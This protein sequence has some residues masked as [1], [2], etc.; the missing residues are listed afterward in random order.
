[1]E[2]VLL[3][4][5]DKAVFFLNTIF[6]PILIGENISLMLNKYPILITFVKMCKNRDGD[7]IFVAVLPGHVSPE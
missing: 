3:V 1:M 2:C 4:K 5:L 7:V 6:H